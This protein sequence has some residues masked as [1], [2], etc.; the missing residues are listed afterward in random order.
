[1]PTQK[2]D[3]HAAPCPWAV[4]DG[5][6]TL[7]VPCEKCDYDLRLLE[8]TGKCPECGHDILASVRGNRLCFATED[9]H[10]RVHSA[11]IWIA[12]AFALLVLGLLV[13][14]S[15]G[16]FVQSYEFVGVI[17]MSVASLAASVL[18]VKGLFI[19]SPAQVDY[20]YA[21]SSLAAPARAIRVAIV[22][23]EL[24][25]VL[26]VGSWATG[27][28]STSLEVVLV[29]L[30]TTGVVLY[31]VADFFHRWMLLRAIGELK[32][33]RNHLRA[34]GWLLVMLG[35]LVIHAIMRSFGLLENALVA[36][37]S[38]LFI[39]FVVFLPIGLSMIE[40]SHRAKFMK[41]VQ[42]QVRLLAAGRSL[43]QYQTP[44]H[45]HADGAFPRAS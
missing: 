29:T 23:L 16:N 15:L 2:L 1:M 41:R 44:T 37:A 9:W 6:V 39:I 22:A 35:F 32:L 12:S 24:A 42:A 36:R 7:G 14:V 26:A 33:V 8:V 13:V 31:S 20:G 27:L 18:V 45:P 17:L 25:F 28:S 30:G 5:R 4:D 11:R 40:V 10:N 34:G 3:D 21:T 38:V 19:R 43:K